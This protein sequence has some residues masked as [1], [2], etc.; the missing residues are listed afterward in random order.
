[1]IILNIVIGSH[2]ILV[3]TQVNTDWTPRNRIQLPRQPARTAI[4]TSLFRL[5][6]L[7]S[8][9][10]NIPPS[11]GTYLHYRWN[12]FRQFLL[13][14]NT[15]SFSLSIALFLVSLFVCCTHQPRSP[16]HLLLHY[17]CSSLFC[18]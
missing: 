12:S 16:L 1:M 3:P 2:N 9:L 6:P 5:P 7:S 13:R 18:S 11:C 10:S 15:L 8:F 17:P 14:F 4:V